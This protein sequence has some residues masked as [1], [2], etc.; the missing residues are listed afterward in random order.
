M[1]KKLKTKT[2]KKNTPQ[3]SAELISSESGT[4]LFEPLE[5][6]KQNFEEQ[7]D[8]TIEEKIEK[9]IRGYGPCN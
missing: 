7:V 1:K 6:A 2:H 3:L 8:R 4:N 5:N 9:N